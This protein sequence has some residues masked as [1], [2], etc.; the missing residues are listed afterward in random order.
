MRIIFTPIWI[1]KILTKFLARLFQS[2][3]I[4][5]GNLMPHALYVGSSLVHAR[6][7][8]FDIKE[9]LY[10]DTD[11]ESMTSL[12]WRPSYRAIKATLGYTFVELCITIFVIAV[13][14]NTAILVVAASR[15]PE[16]A[17]DADLYGMYS[18]FQTNISQAAATIFAIGLLFSGTSAG[19]VA[20]VAGQLVMEGAIIIRINPFVRRLVTRL[21]AI[22]P[23]M[24]VAAAV[25]KQGLGTALNACNVVLSIGLIFLVAPIVWYTSKAKYMTVVVSDRPQLRSLRRSSQES[26]RDAEGDDGECRVNLAN[27]WFTIFW[28]VIAWLLVVILNVAAIVLLALGKSED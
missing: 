12:A 20:T 17:G 16:S 11:G 26:R 18:L 4:V 13:F 23:A 19:V 27:G 21:I 9:E 14:V 15:L 8:E 6:L 22:I 2:S 28:A 5:G 3:A 24:I 25:G 10:P 7:R 1:R